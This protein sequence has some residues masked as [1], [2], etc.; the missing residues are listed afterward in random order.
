MATTLAQG[1]ADLARQIAI[2]QIAQDIKNNETFAKKEDVASSSELTARLL[3]LESK[4]SE[5]IRVAWVESE[6][7]PLTLDVSSD[8]DDNAFSV[9]LAALESKVSEL[10]QKTWKQE[11]LD[12]D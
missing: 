9:R 4:V 2:D 5:L 12:G 8:S 11:P 1:V 6:V 10:E 3:T 7:E